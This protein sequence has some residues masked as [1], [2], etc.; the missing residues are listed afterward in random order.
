MLF[1]NK[2][3]KDYEIFYLKSPNMK[4]ITNALIKKIEYKN[5]SSTISFANNSLKLL[6]ASPSFF[7]EGDLLNIVYD[8]DV[9]KY[10][11]IITQ[12][13]NSYIFNFFSKF[14]PVKKIIDNIISNSFKITNYLPDFMDKIAI[15]S[16]RK[17]NNKYLDLFVS[18]T[19]IDRKLFLKIASAWYYDAYTR[20]LLVLGLTREIIENTFLDDHE[21][22]NQLY[23]Y[24]NPYVFPAIPVNIAHFIEIS[25]GVEVERE[26]INKNIMM[27]YIS[28]NVTKN[29]NNY[30]FLNV[31]L[32]R[33]P[34]LTPE[35]LKDL[36]ERFSLKIDDKYCYINKVF[37]RQE[38]VIDELVKIYRK[39]NNNDK[40]KKLDLSDMNFSKYQ[41]FTVRNVIHNRISVITG[42]AGVGKCLS[43]ETEVL[44][45]DGRYKYA[46]DIL[47]S[48]VLMGPDMKKREITSLCCGV[49]E[50]FTIK[51]TVNSL[52]F[53]CN[54]EHILTLASDSNLKIKFKN[55]YYR[56][57]HTSNN[58]RL[59]SKFKS[60]IDAKN[61]SKNH[62][63]NIYDISVKDFLRKK[64]KNVFLIQKRV[65]FEYSCVSRNIFHWGISSRK[66]RNFMD[67]TSILHNSEDVRLIF[68]KGFFLRKV[69]ISYIPEI[70]ERIV[71]SLGFTCSLTDEL[72][73]CKEFYDKDYKFSLYPFTITHNGKGPYF[74]FDLS[75]S[76]DR[77]FLL[78]NY[79]ITHNTR[80]ITG[81]IKAIDENVRSL[82]E[83]E[84]FY[85][86]KRILGET[87]DNVMKKIALKKKEFIQISYPFLICSFTGKAVSRIK[88]S[89]KDNISLDDFVKEL[90]IKDACTI[91]RLF[92]RKKYISSI[93]YLIIDEASMLTTSLLYEL[94]KKFQ[95]KISRIIFVGDVNQLEPIGFGSIFS[96]IIK[97]SVF[98]IYKLK[99]NYRVQ[100]NEEIKD[101]I[102]INS[103]LIIR[104]KEK[105]MKYFPEDNF[106]IYEVTQE[107]KY[108][109]LVNIYENSILEGNIPKVLVFYNKTR[110]EVN[111]R[112]QKACCDLNECF[113]IENVKIEEEFTEK[114]HTNR[115]F[116]KG[117]LIMQSENDAANNIFNVD[118]GIISEINDNYIN[119]KFDGREKEIKYVT[120]IKPPYYEPGMKKCEKD[121]TLTT[122]SILL[123]YALT[124]DKSQGSEYDRVILFMDYIG[125][126]NKFITWNR[127][128]TGISRSKR[129]CDIITSS[130][131]MFCI[132]SAIN[133]DI[134]LDITHDK[135]KSQLPIIK[136]EEDEEFFDQDNF[137]LGDNSDLPD[138]DD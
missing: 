39:S 108:K 83:Y 126:K 82:P 66:E 115:V 32:K 61:F 54:E 95:D 136:T 84:E 90:A 120:K 104:N 106:K 43:P 63:Y 89:L 121:E 130:R 41:D 76:A 117:D 35:I 40:I 68:L 137:Q 102:I 94:L 38:T 134:R 20:P 132:G 55:N 36:E 73:L 23:Y 59:S 47:I 6:K 27:N 123:A 21:L 46:K 51:S 86:E 62:L 9:L 65:D 48:D 7:K 64:R 88:E 34:K 107:E 79:I 50:M 70:I 81:I 71:N 26:D 57:S 112:I 119:V 2:Y 103:E 138:F 42:G 49:D 77:R 96:Q 52:S 4:E 53:K 133:P 31:F 101:G 8:F 113:G 19:K 109:V 10:S 30:T 29:C 128:Y 1:V 131:E 58:V 33:F 91:N 111:L 5:S 15:K 45:F 74:G 92:T 67:L 114:F 28:D 12:R 24:R 78:G 18:A 87:S 37:E 118:T 75:D 69:K 122:K 72:I 116:Y 3:D 14:I 97:S 135:L 129:F 22:K 16:C 13:S 11:M 85:N 56:V 127:I 17:Y 93:E 100:A 44:L 99:K 124:I 25:I 80:C 105:V 60:E 110:D 98:P 125:L